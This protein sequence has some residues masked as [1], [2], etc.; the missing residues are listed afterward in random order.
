MLLLLIHIAILTF[1]TVVYK[2]LPDGVFSNGDPSW[3]DCLY[4]SASTHTTVGYGDLTPKSPVAKLTATAHMM[5]VFAI[6]VS[7]FTFPW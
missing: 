7:S 4:F 6:V 1:F 3:V 5:I 2:M